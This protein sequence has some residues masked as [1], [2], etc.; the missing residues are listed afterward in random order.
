[1]S[2]DA[3]AALLAL[4]AGPP[5]GGFALDPWLGLTLALFLVFLNGFFVAAEFALVKVRPTQL[6]PHVAGLRRGRVARHMVR[7]LDAYLSAT[8][9]GIT[10]A[11]LALGWIGEPAFAWLVEPLVSL[12]PGAGPALVHSVA[13]TLAF[14]TITILHIVLGELAPK[15]IAIRKAERTA[16]WVA[17]PLYAFYKVSY[18]AIWLLNHAANAILKAIGIEPVSEEELG[19]EE[20]ELRLLLASGHASQLSAAKRELLDNIFE[21]SHRIARQIMVP[22]ADVVY[23]DTTRPVE[24]NLSSARRSGHTRYPLCEGSL[25]RVIGLVHIKD[26]F[27]NAQPLTSLDEVAR[28]I[29][30]VPETLTLDRLLN[31]MLAEKVHMAAVLDEYGGV[32]GIVT[33]ENVIEEIVG[34]IQDEF[35]AEKPEL[36]ALGDGAYLVSGAML[37][38]EVEEALDVEFSDRDEDTIGGVVLSELGRRAVVGDQ[39]ELGPLLLEVEEVHRNRIR[40]LRVTVRQPEP[41]AAGGPA[42]E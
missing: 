5:I 15:S 9:L 13:L 37:V 19:P 24:R 17:M 27:R 6:D 32:S 40:T 2:P 29:A 30:F 23:L 38:E 20:A 1:M 33:L 14:L 39:A 41:A 12:V 4:A 25:D 34:Q 21:L 7:H 10:L 16:L 18:P 42:R 8:Q 28:E 35:D 11:S 26:L 36:T 3:P 22:R 31:R